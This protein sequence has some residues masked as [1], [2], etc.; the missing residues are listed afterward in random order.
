MTTKKRPT[1]TIT[2]TMMH[3]I[4]DLLDVAG[5]RFDDDYERPGYLT[6]EEADA[7]DLAAHTWN[8]DPE[9]HVP[10]EP[11][12]SGSTLMHMFADALRAASG[13]VKEPSADELAARAEVE[14]RKA[15]ERAE[16]SVADADRNLEH[17]KR[18]NETVKKNLAALRAKQ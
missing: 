17:A 15:I 9:Q 3:I 7:L 11:W 8:G 16:Q 12:Y 1:S 4:A 13:P 18:V 10:G 2:P 14:K 6:N 5:E